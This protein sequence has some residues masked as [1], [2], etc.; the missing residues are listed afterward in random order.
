MFKYGK[1]IV[2]FFHPA[3]S[4]SSCC[5]PKSQLFKKVQIPQSYFAVLLGFLLTLLRE[6]IYTRIQVK[7]GAGENGYQG[8]RVL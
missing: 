5:S 6:G 1:G 3:P 7:L 4:I 2:L 8:Y